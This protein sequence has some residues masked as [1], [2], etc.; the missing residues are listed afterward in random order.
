MKRVWINYAVDILLL[1]TGLILALSSLLIWV[2]LPKGFNTTWLVWIS[3]HKWSG[4]ALVVESLLH[5]ALHWKWLLT[6]TKRA[7]GGRRQ[8]TRGGSSS[9]S[10]TGRTGRG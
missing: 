8:V 5:V 10:T 1:A 4:F 9:G 6:M 7:F 3:I 2:V